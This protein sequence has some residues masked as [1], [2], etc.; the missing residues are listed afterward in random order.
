[1]GRSILIICYYWPPAGG[2]GVQRWLKFATYLNKQGRDVHVIVPENADYPVTDASLLQEVPEGL[3]LIKVPIKEPS[4]WAS[5]LSRK[6]TKSLQKGILSKRSS[7][8]EQLLLW[9]RGNFFIPDARIGW[10]QAVVKQAEVFL[11]Q[12]PQTTVI[13]S[14]PPHSIHL[15]GMELSRRF[16]SIHWIADFRDPWTTIG[17]HKDLKLSKQAAKKH[18]QL[19]QEVLETADAILVTSKATQSE[20]KRKTSKRVVLITNGFDIEISQDLSQPAG[21][22]TVSHVGTLLSDRNPLALWKALYRLTQENSRFSEVFKL[23]LAGNVSDDV[24]QSIREAG[25]ER[26]LQL[27]GYLDH[28]EAVQLMQQ[29]QSLLLIEIDSVETQAI[30]PGKLFEYLASRRPITA[31]GPPKADVKD[32]ILE[33]EAGSYFGYLQEDLLFNHFK[34]LF[35]R[36]TAGENT[37]NTKESFLKYHRKETTQSLMNEIDRLWE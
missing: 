23:Q 32:M 31:I 9:L 34:R 30:I 5:K 20:F 26:Y 16:D 3:N 1:M 15:S 21:D 37:A 24:V 7:R 6:R 27:M 14:G 25:L 33:H 17:Y 12:Y 8:V 28:D 2:P 11:S 19:E 22:F 4:R 35:E 10:K 36:Y 18:E 13:T 29:S